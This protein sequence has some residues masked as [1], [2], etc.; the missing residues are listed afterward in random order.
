MCFREIAKKNRPVGRCSVGLSGLYGFQRSG[1]SLNVNRGKAPPD[2]DKTMTTT[3]L[4]K[5]DKGDAYVTR[6]TVGEMS[7]I[8]TSDQ[9]TI[10]GQGGVVEKR[11]RFGVTQYRDV[12]PAAKWW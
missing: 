11:D 7:E 2:G 9:L 5:P 8:F 1:E 12:L 3:L 4:A 10:L 6:F